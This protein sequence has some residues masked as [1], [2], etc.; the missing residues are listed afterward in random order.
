MP[1]DPPL[2]LSRWS[3]GEDYGYAIANGQ[4][5]NNSSESLENVEAVVTYYDK[6]GQFITS[7]DALIEYNPLLAGQSSPFRVTTRWNPA[8]ATAQLEFK[9][10]MG[11]TI[12]HTEPGK[13]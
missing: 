10:L 7:D 9:T 8:M 4:V 12:A 6:N 3:W 13:K 2:R 1:A 11:G 5:K